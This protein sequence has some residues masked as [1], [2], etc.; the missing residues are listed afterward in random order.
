MA[1]TSLVGMRR[2]PTIVAP[3]RC[4]A[5]QLESTA[6]GSNWRASCCRWTEQLSLPG[7]QSRFCDNSVTVGALLGAAGVWIERK[8]KEER[9]LSSTLDTLVIIS[10]CTKKEVPLYKARN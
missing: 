10:H 6:V 4:E 7:N 1:W 2:A 3:R 8:S 9:D 5:F